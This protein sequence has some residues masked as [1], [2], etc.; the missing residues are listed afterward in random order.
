ALD[1]R[2]REHSVQSAGCAGSPANVFQLSEFGGSY[3]QC[4]TQSPFAAMNLV[5]VSRQASCT[6]VQFRP[7]RLSTP[8]HSHL[9]HPHPCRLHF[10]S[11]IFVGSHL[12]ASIQRHPVIEQNG[13][14][15]NA[16]GVRAA[17]GS[18]DWSKGRP[19]RAARRLR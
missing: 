13:C 18:N 2:P 5:L 6:V 9:A 16:E 10:S 14:N 4:K 11:G 3:T 8:P 15:R 7:E 12:A 17:G 19:D 1:R